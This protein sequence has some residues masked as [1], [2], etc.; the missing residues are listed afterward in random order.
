MADNVHTW[1][2]L[3]CLVVVEVLDDVEKLEDT[4]TQEM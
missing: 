3:G 4:V 1:E 2:L